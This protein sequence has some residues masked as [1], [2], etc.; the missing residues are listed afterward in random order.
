MKTSKI[1]A[2]CLS[3][4][5]C[6]GLFSAC[7][8]TANNKNKSAISK[9][10]PKGTANA[11]DTTSMPV[12][13][14]DDYSFKSVDEAL[15]YVKENAD[16]GFAQISATADILKKMMNGAEPDEGELALLNDP[17]SIDQKFLEALFYMM[18]AS[19]EQK[20]TPEQE[21]EIAAFANEHQ[22]GMQDF[23]VIFEV[24]AMSQ[25]QM[26]QQGMM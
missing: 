22:A 5:L 21:A 24:A 13:S 17:N 8:D 11:G 2:A 18:H 6:V 25:Q 20:T 26:A 4:L 16:L 9:T 7:N 12:M 14:L 1:I 10:A 3:L 15:A 23:G 19:L